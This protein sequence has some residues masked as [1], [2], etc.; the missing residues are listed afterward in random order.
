MSSI[1]PSSLTDDELVRYAQMYHDRKES[2]PMA[3]QQ[4]LLKRFDALVASLPQ[5][6]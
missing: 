1:Q 5:R 6:F 3:W 2:L 4:E